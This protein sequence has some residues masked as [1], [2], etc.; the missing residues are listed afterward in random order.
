MAGDVSL[1]LRE[2]IEIP[3]I[4]P[5]L[6]APGEPSWGEC[7]IANYIAKTLERIGAHVIRQPILHGR[8]NIVGI[9][10]GRD[11]R[12]DVLLCAHMDT[13]S[14]DGMKSPP[15]K[16]VFKDCRVYGRGA[17]DT[18]AS[19]AAMLTALKRVAA[20]PD[21]HKGTMFAATVDEEHA[22]S[23]AKALRDW[24]KE[25]FDE[26]I[27]PKLCI[28][29]EPTKLQIA[30]AHK[31]FLRSTIRTRGK[32]AHSSQPHIGINAIYRMAKVVLLLERF[33]YEV[34]SKHS[35]PL[36]GNP[37]LSVGI[38]RGGYAPN[39]VPD[40]C[41]VVVDYRI[42]P[43]QDPI[44]MWQ[45]LREFV[46]SSSEIDFEVEFDPPN[47]IDTGMETSPN[48]ELVRELIEATASVI[49]E[50]KLVGVPYSTDASK[51]ASIGIPSVVFG[52]GDIKQAHSADEFV[53]IE[54]VEK[55]AAIIERLL[56]A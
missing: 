20:N 33:S 46:C 36:L 56:Q 25:Q 30:I 32:S 3:S 27:A 54:E 19:I 24:L 49:G 51:F 22:A 9:L 31:G 6:A 45:K 39:V 14:G 16:A 44:E 38:I 43:S 12:V 52:P 40:R 15:F 17:C 10:A 21:Q 7:Q 8:E 11:K 53:E 1:I 18:K 42:F 35:H 55:C 2:L 41:E 4:N 47:L 29:G 5:A 48:E 26:G 28:V 50:A 34:L 37:T 23:G 13:V